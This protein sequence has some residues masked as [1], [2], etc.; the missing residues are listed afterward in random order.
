MDVAEFDKNV[1]MALPRIAEYMEELNISNLHLEQIMQNPE[2]LDLFQKMIEEGHFDPEKKYGFSKT[3]LS[4]FA[5]KLDD[6]EFEAARPGLQEFIEGISDIPFEEL[7]E[8]PEFKR[9]VQDA[10]QKGHFDLQEHAETYGFSRAALVEFTKRVET[11]EADRMQATPAASGDVDHSREA[12]VSVTYTPIRTGVPQ[13][14]LVSVSDLQETLEA[15]KDSLQLRTGQ[16]GT[17]DIY[18]S[19]KGRLSVSEEDLQRVF[20]EQH[21][22]LLE[23]MKLRDGGTVAFDSNG[24]TVI[25]GPASEGEVDIADLEAELAA[26]QESEELLA[27]IEE[28]G[29]GLPGP[30]VDEQDRGGVNQWNPT[31]YGD[32]PDLDGLDVSEGTPRGLCSGNFEVAACGEH[33]AP[34]IG[35]QV[36]EV[37][38]TLPNGEPTVADAILG[39]APNDQPIPEGAIRAEPAK[40]DEPIPEDAVIQYNNAGL[41]LN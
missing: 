12:L 25:E 35:D 18:I 34:L 14:D 28:I 29:E 24:Q 5:K 17:V 2:F 6:I 3:V 33:T 32:A 40:A 19:G 22:E 39:R 10:I 16:D 36:Y 11:I 38:P 8:N 4:E 37:Q 20:P 26:E 15:Q 21:A 30:E 27:A 13:Q 7:L 31:G 9:L 41:G 1:G 23:Q